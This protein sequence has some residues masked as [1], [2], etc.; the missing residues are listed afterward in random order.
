MTRLVRITEKDGFGDM[1]SYYILL[2][3]D[4]A[5]SV[6]ICYNSHAVGSVKF[7]HD[8]SLIASVGES[9]HWEFDEGMS[10]LHL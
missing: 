9:S 1:S 6:P 3:E 4:S 5:D 8:G 2:G 7:G 10:S